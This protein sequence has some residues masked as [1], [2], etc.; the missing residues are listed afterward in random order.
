MARTTH[1]RAHTQPHAM[2]AKAASV[3]MLATMLTPR[4]IDDSR[5]KVRRAGRALDFV[6]ALI[7]LDASEYAHYQRR[8]LHL[9]PHN[10]GALLAELEIRDER[11]P[12]L[13]V[14][15]EDPAG[16]AALDLVARRP[17]NN[18]QDVALVLALRARTVALNPAPSVLLRVPAPFRGAAVAVRLFLADAASGRHASP[19]S[20]SHQW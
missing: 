13:V 9:L 2:V 12:R 17:V 8:R 19:P 18:G 4:Q 11:Q 1:T 7:S 14:V 5:D 16:V 20:V 10:R 3:P 6:E 15:L